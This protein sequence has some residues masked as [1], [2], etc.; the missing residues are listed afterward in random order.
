M[1]QSD[2]DFDAAKAVTEQLKGMEKAR[3]QRILRWVVES[4]SLDLG[5]APATERR[6]AETT[7]SRAGTSQEEAQL[8]HRHQRPANI[9]SFVDSKR[10]KNDVQFTTVVAY[11]YRFEASP[12]NQKNTIDAE[13]LQQA[14]RDTGRR[15]TP[16]PLI[17]LNNAKKLGYLDSAERG[18][19]RINSIGENLVAMT[20]PGTE[21]ART[22]KKARPTKSRKATRKKR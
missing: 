11:Y 19:Y 22:R 12:E 10:P 6:M 21:P 15:R 13:V 7:A 18:Q 5:T 16:R 8:L 3:Q 17:T 2:S 4:L 14:A 9:K 20:L 1:A